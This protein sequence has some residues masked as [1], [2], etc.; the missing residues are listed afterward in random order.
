M[1]FQ[2]GLTYIDFP[3]YIYIYFPI[4]PLKELPIAYEIWYVHVDLLPLDALG[5]RSR[6]LHGDD[7]GRELAANN[8]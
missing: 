3:I 1:F 6:S 4:G 5:V 8:W 2:I 7:D